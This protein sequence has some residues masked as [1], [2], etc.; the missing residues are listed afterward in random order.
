MGELAALPSACPAAPGG[1]RARVHASGRAPPRAAAVTRAPRRGAQVN[2]T[3]V[4]LSLKEWSLDTRLLGRKALVASLTRHY[5][6]QALAEAHKARAGRP[7]PR[8]LLRAR[9]AGWVVCIRC[10]GPCRVSLRSHCCSGAPT[11]A[12]RCLTG[13][14]GGYCEPGGTGC[15]R[16]RASDGTVAWSSS[17]RLNGSDP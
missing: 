15:Y 6:G 3:N 12:A 2:V 4:P 9:H 8:P 5:F 14:S 16:R 11:A 10:I 17:S 1:G 7:R 13:R